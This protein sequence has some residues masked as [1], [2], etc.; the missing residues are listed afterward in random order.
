MPNVREIYLAG[1]KALGLDA[2]PTENAEE[3]AAEQV[4]GHLSSETLKYRSVE[5][6]DSLDETREY[7]VTFKNGCGMD[8]SGL[9]LKHNFSLDPATIES[10]EPA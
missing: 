10:I 1:R 5:F 9:A 2:P 6:L 8:A 3:E 7:R 4:E